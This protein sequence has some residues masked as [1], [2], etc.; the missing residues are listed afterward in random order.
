MVLSHRPVQMIEKH[1]V[2]GWH[3][4]LRTMG[5]WALQRTELPFRTAT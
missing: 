4:W 3:N 5:S 2:L 1:E